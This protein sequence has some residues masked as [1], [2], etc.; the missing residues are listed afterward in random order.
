MSWQLRATAGPLAGAVY[1]LRRRVTLGRAG[2]CDIQIVDDGVSRQHAKVVDAEGSYELVDLGSNNGTFVGD[3]RIDRHPLRSGDV[4]RVM[5][6]H[7]IY[8]PAP[9]GMAPDS[10]SAGVWAVKV[11][12]GQTLRQTVD[13]MHVARRARPGDTRDDL[14]A[15]EREA[16]SAASLGRVTSGEP[17]R[18]RICALHPD[19]RPYEGDVVG[20][21]LM[22][23]ELQLRMSRQ[24]TLTPVEH[25]LLQ[26]FVDT[27]SQPEQGD[28]SPYARLR[29]FVRLRCRF[30][31]R[32]RWKEQ[33]V[34][35]NAAVMVQDVG[36]GGARLAWRE[37]PLR[38]G[39]VTWLVIDVVAARRPKTLVFPTRV[40]WATG[41]DL[42]LQ[43]AGMVEWEPLRPR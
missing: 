31:A 24:E 33:G 23:R 20:D 36:V 22:F 13:H 19:G 16:Q 37:H 35:Q 18:H 17:E 26:Q 4:V 1:V 7:F 38:E 41:V 11:V 27:F 25:Q 3:D 34:E 30:P 10:H 15:L 2:D 12:N 40:A 14:Q 28:P 39:V 6:S 21:I 29:R 5:G 8:E 32:V 43:F 9:D 42:G